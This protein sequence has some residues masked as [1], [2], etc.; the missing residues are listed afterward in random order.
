MSVLTTGAASRF[1]GPWE[2]GPV[3]SGTV[4]VVVVAAAMAVGIFGT[5]VPL[6]P[7][8]GLVWLAGLAYGLI[9]GFGGVG[10]AAF[11]VMTVLAGAGTLAGV[12]VPGRAAGAAGASRPSLALGVA[13]AVVGFFVVPVIGALAGGALGIFLG[14]QLR[15]RDPATA[16]RATRATLAGMGLASLIQLGAGI[17]MS[18]TWVIW[19]VAR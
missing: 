13:L 7:G 11:A 18:L 2:P 6:V 3:E 9:E 14:E 17:V 10:L 1:P 5:V 12:V 19:V 16:W 15:S 8:L 4:V